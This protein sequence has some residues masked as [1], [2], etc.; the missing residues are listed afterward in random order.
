MRR[1]CPV[2][3]PAPYACKSELVQMKII[4]ESAYKDIKDKIIC[5]FRDASG[6]AVASLRD[7]DSDLNRPSAQRR[8]DSRNDPKP[9]SRPLF[10]HACSTPV[11]G[12]ESF[13]REGRGLGRSRRLHK[14]FMAHA[15]APPADEDGDSSRRKKARLGRASS[16]LPRGQRG[17]TVE[18]R[19]PAQPLS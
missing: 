1:T 13:W 19:L 9:T 7:T 11:S 12:R 16:L 15:T 5:R 14:G 18:P 2:I 6:R 8:P 3:P 4:T 10:E 17:R